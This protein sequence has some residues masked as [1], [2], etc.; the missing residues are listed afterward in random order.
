MMID[1][2]NDP[3]YFWTFNDIEFHV[4]ITDAYTPIFINKT[5]K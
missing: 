2:G 3:F 4:D 5:G 1:F